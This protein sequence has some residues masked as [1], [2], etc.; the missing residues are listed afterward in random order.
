M[1][2]KK[3]CAYQENFPEQWCQILVNLTKMDLKCGNFFFRKIN[4]TVSSYKFKLF[5]IVTLSKIKKIYE[6]EKLFHFFKAAFKN[7]ASNVH[8]LKQ[9]EI[10]WYFGRVNFPDISGLNA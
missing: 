5:S 9:K 2:L 3:D 10:Y 8:N 1:S 6:F 4:F 7:S